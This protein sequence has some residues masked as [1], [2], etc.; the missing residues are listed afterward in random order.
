[1]AVIK[2]YKERHKRLIHHVYLV[3]HF[4][5]LATVC[6]SVVC[7]DNMKRR[8]YGK[9]TGSQSNTWLLNV[10][11]KEN[12]TTSWTNSS[13]I[14]CLYNKQCVNVITWTTGERW[15]QELEGPGLWSEPQNWKNTTSSRDRGWLFE[16]VASDPVSVTNPGLDAEL[17]CLL[18]NAWASGC[19]HNCWGQHD[20]NLQTDV[21][22]NLFLAIYFLF[23]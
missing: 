12:V 16:P 6:G 8:L 1:M 14:S 2:T 17:N 21:S 7:T 22:L 18:G 3:Y 13:S 11:L 4:H 9:D 10:S 19:F 5:I 20:E 15:S 23:W